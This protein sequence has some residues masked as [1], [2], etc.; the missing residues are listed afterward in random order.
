MFAEQALY[1]LKLLTAIR[2]KGTL[3]MTIC[4][5][6]IAGTLVVPPQGI[7]AI[8][9]NQTPKTYVM[10]LNPACDWEFRDK[11]DHYMHMNNTPYEL[12]LDSYRVICLGGVKN[13]TDIESYILPSLRSDL[14]D[15]KFVFVYPDSMVEQ[16]NNYIEG[17]FGPEYRYLAL[18]STDIPNGI[19]YVSEV[20]AS[21]KHEMA[22][23]ATCGTWHNE[24]G[25]D[26][27]HLVRHPQAD[28]LPWCPH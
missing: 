22:H 19:A 14:P 15:D 7:S 1:C 10:L 16:F 9:I 13:L 11:F 12:Y 25:E 6:L 23:L 21:V 17:K 5:L 26:I 2:G 24:Q 18:G 4:A 27:G 28:F 20:P 3:L 8:A